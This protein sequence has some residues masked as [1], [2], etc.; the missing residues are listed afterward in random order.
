MK[1]RTT[2]L[3]KHLQTLQ[4]D[5]VDGARTR[6][7][8]LQTGSLRFERAIGGGSFRQESF[9]GSLHSLLR[10]FVFYSQHVT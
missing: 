2:L 1:M 8:I 3:M 4:V 9:T 5:R 10:C 7:L 6:E